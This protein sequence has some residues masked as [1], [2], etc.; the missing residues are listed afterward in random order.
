VAVYILILLLN[1]SKQVFTSA[2]QFFQT[3][4]FKIRKHRPGIDFITVNRTRGCDVI[5]QPSE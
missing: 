4:T 2:V 5:H 3:K 1:T